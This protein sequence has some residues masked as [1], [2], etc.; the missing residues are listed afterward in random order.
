MRQDRK[1]HSHTRTTIQATKAGGVTSGSSGSLKWTSLSRCMPS[2]QPNGFRGNCSYIFSVQNE[3][4]C[5]D[6]TVQVLNT[7]RTFATMLSFFKL[8]SQIST[9]LE[10]KF[11]CGIKKI[12]LRS[13]LVIT[14]SKHIHYI[15]K[16]EIVFNGTT[17]TD[18]SKCLRPLKNQRVHHHQT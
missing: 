2:G 6:L 8:S 7:G 18:Q 12:A 9:G 11:K 1:I 13:R 15:E 5:S 14:I 16:A 17:K 10:Y 3:I 4:I